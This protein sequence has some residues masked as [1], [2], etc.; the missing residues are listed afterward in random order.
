MRVC[1]VLKSSYQV[2]MV[3]ASYFLV[4]SKTKE[5]ILGADFYLNDCSVEVLSFSLFAFAVKLMIFHF[6]NECFL[7]TLDFH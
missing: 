2:S 3:E 4:I 5:I 6:F 7:S 1:S